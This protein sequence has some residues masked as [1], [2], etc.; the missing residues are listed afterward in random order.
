M[1]EVG[2][3]SK[4]SKRNF[5]ARD[6]TVA[7]EEKS[8]IG[9]SQTG[10]DILPAPVESEV[11]QALG[12]YLDASISGASRKAILSDCEVFLQWSD[13]AGFDGCFPATETELAEFVAAIAKKRAYNTICRYMSSISKV[14][15][16]H[17]WPNPTKTELVK[18]AIRG[19]S[20]TELRGVRQAR[21]LRPSEL[22]LCLDTLSARSWSGHRNQALLCVGWLAALRVSEIT[23]LAREDV[24]IERAE[25]EYKIIVTVRRSK[26]DQ[27][28]KGKR[29][30]IPHS[31][32]SGIIV[33]WHDRLSELYK[34]KNGHGP[35]F[36]S[37]GASTIQRYF[38][39]ANED[40]DRCMSVRSVA[41]LINIIFRR[42]GL[43]AG[44]SGH[45]LRRGLI[46]TAAELG[47]PT[48]VIQRHSRHLSAET[49]RGYIEAGSIFDDNPLPAILDRFFSPTEEL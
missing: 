32:L 10:N 21:A 35:F 39:W 48:H 11:S 18:S 26:T 22:K 2:N 40:Q 7:N 36:P 43:G 12:L 33:S 30:G 20:R 24:E 9:T 41:R 6:I 16:L 17:G 19:V 15:K 14:H 13:D 4:K 28:G 3:K 5:Q 27:T 23:R 47:I 25:G 31:S 42:A 34:A 1:S 44:Y 29:L 37:F 49:M 8:R 46:T 45:S 38:P